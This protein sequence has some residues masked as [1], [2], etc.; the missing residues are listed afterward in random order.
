MIQS[1]KVFGGQLILRIKE[2][3]GSFGCD[4][5]MFLGLLSKTC[6]NIL[7]TMTMLR[8]QIRISGLSDNKQTSVLNTH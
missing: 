1:K 7:R 8:I 6:L 2:R 3:L 5:D 4:Q